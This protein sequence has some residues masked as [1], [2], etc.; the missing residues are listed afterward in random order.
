MINNFVKNINPIEQKLIENFWPGKLTIIF[1]KSDI[2]P[3]LLTSGFSTVG[4][5]MPNNKMC[6]DIIEKFG[7]PIAMSSANISDEIPDN[8][9]K[10]LLL[11]F[12]NKVSFIINDN[13]IN[14]NIPST[15]VRVEGNCIKLIRKGIISVDD[16]KNCFGGNIDV[17]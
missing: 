6:L 9:L 4:I 11:D 2:V 17:R 8:N 12:D 16:I 10:S 15:I 5:R 13:N 14:Q 7:K 1:D 3:D